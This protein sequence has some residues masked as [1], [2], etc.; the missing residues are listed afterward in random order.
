M[1]ISLEIAIKVYN[2][3]QTWSLIWEIW[4]WHPF[5]SYANILHIFGHPRGQKGHKIGVNLPISS[6]IL[7]KSHKFGQILYL[8]WEIWWWHP[9][10][11]YANILLVFGHHRGQKGHKIGVNLPISSQIVIKPHK[12]GQIL[13]LTWEIWWWHPFLSYANILPIL[14]TPGVKRGTK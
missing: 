2:F 11:S 9:F 3:G 6:Q 7:I 14:G 1:P 13:Y 10:L 5:L 12:F 8:T 4:W